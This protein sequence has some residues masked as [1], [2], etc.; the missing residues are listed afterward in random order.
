V[1]EYLAS[2]A[3]ESDDEVV[4]VNISW[5]SQLESDEFIV[6]VG[7]DSCTIENRSLPCFLIRNSVRFKFSKHP[8]SI[9]I[10]IN[11]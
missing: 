1:D 8:L 2:A 4:Q 7:S 6:A 10:A 11:I 3:W 5:C 9:V